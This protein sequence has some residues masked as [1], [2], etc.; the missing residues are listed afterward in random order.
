VTSP[1]DRRWRQVRLLVLRR[2]GYLC[3]IQGPGCAGQA[4]AVDHVI[5]LRQGGPRLDPGNLVAACSHCNSAK[6]NRDREPRSERWY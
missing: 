5:A 1:Y 6:G 2:D 3:Q 4:D